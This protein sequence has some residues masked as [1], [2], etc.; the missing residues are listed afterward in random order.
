VQELRTQIEIHEALCE[1]LRRRHQ[2]QHEAEGRKQ[3]AALQNEAG[4]FSEKL[5]AWQQRGLDLWANVEALAAEG[6]DLQEARAQ[7]SGRISS[8]RSEYGEALS[9]V[10]VPEFHRAQIDQDA[11]PAMRVAALLWQRFEHARRCLN[12]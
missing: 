11:G 3:A 9:G 7:L 8:L 1:A 5:D 2:E 12:W 6:T 4:E 10:T